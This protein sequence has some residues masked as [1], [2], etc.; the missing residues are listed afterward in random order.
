MDSHLR[1]KM[2]A[3]GWMPVIF[4]FL[5]WK[6]PKPL[7]VL[8]GCMC[9]ISGGFP[10]GF[11]L[12]LSVITSAVFGTLCIQFFL[13]RLFFRRKRLVRNVELPDVIEIDIHLLG[14]FSAASVRRMHHNL[15][16]K[17]L[18]HGCGQF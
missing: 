9:V 17:C 15:F 18:D 1:K 14:A 7:F 10:L 13:G 4:Y 6:F 11:Q 12:F 2:R 5:W 3:S 16:H 8:C